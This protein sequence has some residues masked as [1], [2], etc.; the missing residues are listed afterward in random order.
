VDPTGFVIASQQMCGS[1]STSEIYLVNTG[2][3]GIYLDTGSA[4]GSA[5]MSLYTLI[6][7]SGTVNT[8]DTY[9]KTVLGDSPIAYWRLDEAGPPA[10]ENAS[11]SLARVIGPTS[12]DT[13]IE[14]NST[15]S[16]FTI[17]AVNNPG[18]GSSVTG[19]LSE[20]L[21]FKTT[22]SNGGVLIG[23]CDQEFNI[24]CN[25]NDRLIY[26]TNSGQLIFGTQ[27]T[28]TIESTNS[29]NDGNWHYAVGTWN[30][31][32]LN[33]YVDGTFI[34]SATGTAGNYTGYWHIGSNSNIRSTWPS[35]PSSLN[36]DGALGE[37]AVFPY[38]LS[39]TQISN[40]LSQA[41][42]G[43]YDS[44]VL[45]D[46]PSYYWKLNEASGTV[47]ADATGGGNTAISN[48]PSDNG[49]YLGSET[50]SQPGIIASDSAV[51]FDGSTGWVSGLAA[52]TVGSP[53]GS[54]SEEVWF[55]TTTTSGRALLGFCD[56]PLDN[57]CTN[58][59]QLYMTNSGQIIFGTTFNDSGFYTVETTASYND[60]NWHY[61]VGTLSNNT[62]SLYIDGALIGATASG[63]PIIGGYW[64]IGANDLVNWPSQPTSS[65]FAGT[66][67]EPAIYIYALSAAQVSSH[68][69]A[70]GR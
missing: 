54:F 3:Y 21:W 33:F 63:A 69:Q 9:A 43:K 46:N 67:D 37:I 14:L 44:A 6:D 1:G 13:A 7:M 35:Q 39:A 52:Y 42:T 16:F 23:F 45:A 24:N 2:R 26:M 58:S 56:H 11:P 4:A 41:K 48:A 5:T 20:E 70:S 66:I 19:G 60:G 17:V 27:N 10:A 65:Y 40:H 32:T 28:S 61:V 22:T 62:M 8:S 12:P 25:Q 38:A 50:F 57:N 64:H 29:Y 55:K 53:S 34:G 47:F 68:Y 31:N 15:G 49:V 18:P 51:T 59:R 36:F 30:L